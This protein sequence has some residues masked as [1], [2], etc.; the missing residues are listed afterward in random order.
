VNHP[1][2]LGIDVSTTSAKALLVDRQGQV[3]ASASS[4]LSLSTPNPLWSEQNPHDWWDASAQSIRQALAQAGVEGSAVQAI[5]LTGQ[6]HGLVLL[7]E[8]GQVLRPAILWNDQRTAAECEEITELLGFQRLLSITGNKALTG[9]TAP[10]ILWVRKH[11]PQ[12][13][14]RRPHP[15]AK[16]Y[17]RCA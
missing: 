7:D 15:A 2:L 16:D 12:V 1:L 6:M 14:A 5:G 4:T 11:E 8:V 9:F 17:V 10:K 13:T 3:V